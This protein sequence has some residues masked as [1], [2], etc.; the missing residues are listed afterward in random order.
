MLFA[1]DDST[2]NIA[3]TIANETDAKIYILDPIT[4]GDGNYMEYIEKMS[5]NIKVIQEAYYE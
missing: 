1:A 4:T 5:N 3:K 2:L